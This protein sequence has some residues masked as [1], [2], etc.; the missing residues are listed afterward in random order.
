MIIDTY[1]HVF[2][3][4]FLQ[5]KSCCDKLEIWTRSD[6]NSTLKLKKTIKGELGYLKVNWTNT[7]QTSLYWTTGSDDDMRPNMDGLLEYIPL[8]FP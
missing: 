3:F 4:Q 2:F 5:S 7:A 1:S 8:N 6:K